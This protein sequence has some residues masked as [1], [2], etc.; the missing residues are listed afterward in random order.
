MKKPKYKLRPNEL[1][2]K[3]NTEL[4]SLKQ[5]LTIRQKQ[6]LGKKAIHK[7]EDKE[8][9][10]LKEVKRN[11]ARVNTLINQRQ[12]QLIPPQKRPIK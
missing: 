7:A 5:Q 10:E 1:K 4:N 8:L 6:L 12:L 3:S 11:I 2:N 9:R